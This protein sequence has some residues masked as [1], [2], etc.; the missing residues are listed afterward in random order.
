M[1]TLFFGLLAYWVVNT[2]RLQLKQSGINHY[3]TQIVRVMSTQKAVTTEAF[4]ALGEKVQTRICSEPTKEVAAIY[5]A[6]NYKDRP[7]RK[8]KIC[9]TQHESQKNEIP[10]LQRDTS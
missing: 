4:N 7:F 2:I 1:L 3:W 6:L 10:I 5:K 8:I 9:S